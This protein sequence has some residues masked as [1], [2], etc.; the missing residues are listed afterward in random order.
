MLFKLKR[1]IQRGGTGF[2]PVIYDGA[3]VGPETRTKV[4]ATLRLVIA[5]KA[6]IHAVTTSR[7]APFRVLPIT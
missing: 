5:A 6:A 2:Q 7:C 4:R 1:S 3:K